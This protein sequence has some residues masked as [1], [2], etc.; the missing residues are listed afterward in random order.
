LA[1]LSL[2]ALLG[3]GLAARH[4][5]HRS[6]IDS[7]VVADDY[8]RSA[9]ARYPVTKAPP[10]VVRMPEPPFG[11]VTWGSRH[12]VGDHSIT[13]HLAYEYVPVNL[14]RLRLLD[15][16]V[17]L[18]DVRVEYFVGEQV[19]SPGDF[20][21]DLRPLVRKLAGRSPATGRRTS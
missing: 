14:V 8:V 11:G 16:G 13:T 1:A 21:V 20:V 5:L 12:D 10:V 9:L 6:V 15:R 19:P 18:D 3:G 7:S 17:G 4:D 2:L